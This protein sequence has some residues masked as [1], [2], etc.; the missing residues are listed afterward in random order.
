M[1]TYVLIK[2]K[3][4]KAEYLFKADFLEANARYVTTAKL[5][6]GFSLIYTLTRVLGSG[7]LKLLV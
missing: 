2:V 7:R 6:I 5:I 3:G 4:R 1:G